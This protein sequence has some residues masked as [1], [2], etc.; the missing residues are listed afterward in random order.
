MIILPFVSLA[1][2]SEFLNK[3][4]HLIYFCD[5][6]LFKSNFISVSIF[7][8]KALFLI[9]KKYHSIRS[10]LLVHPRSHYLMFQKRYC[11]VKRLICRRKRF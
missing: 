5:F 10:L 9:L 11:F 4:T 7:Q 3:K 8:I 6:L 1:I 2:T